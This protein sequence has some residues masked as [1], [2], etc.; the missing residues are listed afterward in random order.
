MGWP[1]LQQQQ[2][3]H[4]NPII[5]EWQKVGIIR[6]CLSSPLI[7]C[8]VNIGS[9]TDRF[10]F[11][12]WC[13][14]T[15]L[16]LPLSLLLLLLLYRSTPQSV[17]KHLNRI[18]RRV[19]IKVETNMGLN[20]VEFQMNTFSPAT[21]INKKWQLQNLQNRNVETNLSL[22]VDKIIHYQCWVLYCT[23]VYKLHIS[24]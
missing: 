20:R 4:I 21:A 15:Q 10:S 13:A 19:N 11:A 24:L 18:S 1:A 6:I 17:K 9:Y 23:V 2:Q 3:Q 8:C 14:Q 22:R 7:I 12:W 16:S 5:K